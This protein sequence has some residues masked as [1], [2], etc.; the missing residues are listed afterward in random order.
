MSL[1]AQYKI[2]IKTGNALPVEY[3][4]VCAEE[5]SAHSRFNVDLDALFEQIAEVRAQVDAI[6]R[7]VRRLEMGVSV[8]DDTDIAGVFD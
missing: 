4:N 2:E 7:N 8:V 6:W 5:E 1:L 3:L